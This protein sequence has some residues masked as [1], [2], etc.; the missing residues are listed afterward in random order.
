M[1]VELSARGNSDLGK[2]LRCLLI[3]AVGSVA[4]VGQSHAQQVP[5]SVP[6]L[7]RVTAYGFR[8]S[9]LPM[10]PPM[11]SLNTGPLASMN[12]NSI[13]FFLDGV[14]QAGDFGYDTERPDPSDPSPGTAINP[15][16]DTQCG[17][18]D[19]KAPPAIQNNPVNVVDGYK[20]ASAV[21]FQSVSNPDLR[22]ER[23]KNP[24]WKGIGVLG[25][26]WVTNLDLK[27][28]FSKTG[29]MCYPTPGKPSCNVSSPT[30]LHFYTDQGGVIQMTKSGGNWH[31][32][33]TA[34]MYWVS[35]IDDGTAD[36]GKYL[37]HTRGGSAFGPRMVFRRNGFIDYIDQRDGNRLT[38]TYDTSN[39]LTKVTHTSGRAITLSWT[40]ATPGAVTS[41]QAPNGGVYRFGYYTAG[42]AYASNVEAPILRTV[43]YPDGKGNLEYI[44]ETGTSNSTGTPRP[45]TNVH[46]ML[47]IK[48]NGVPIST[49]TYKL[50]G[51]N[52][53]AV[54]TTQ[55]ANGANRYVYNY[56]FNGG[57]R[58]VI[59][60]YQK[61]TTYHVEDGQIVETVGA[62]TTNCPSTFKLASYLE[63]GLLEYASDER[64]IV[65][66]YEYDSFGRRTK[67]IEAAG[68]PEQRVTT[69]EYDADPTNVL[70]TELIKSITVSGLRRTTYT[71]TPSASTFPNGNS[72]TA[73]VT[74][75]NL[76]NT[77]VANQDRKTSYSY[78][79]HSNGMIATSTED[80]PL[81]GT[82]DR[83]V[84]SYNPL[85]DLV[86]IQNGLGHKRTFSGHNAF[87][88]PT[89][90]TNENGDIIEYTYDLRGRIVKEAR[91]Y[92]GARTETDYLYDLNGRLDSINK[93][94]GASRIFRYDVVGRLI[95][96][97]EVQPNGKYAFESYDYNAAS[98]IVATYRGEIASI[99]GPVNPMPASIPGED[100]G[101]IIAPGIEVSAVPT[102]ATVSYRSI[103]EYDELGRPLRIRGANGQSIRRTYDESGNLATQT[104]AQNN[105]KTFEYD[106]LDRLITSTDPRGKSTRYTYNAADQVVRVTDP[107]GLVT[108]YSYDGFGALWKLTSPDTGVTN[109]TLDA[110]GRVTK[111]VRA[112]GK[113]VIYTHDSLGRILTAVAGGQT[114]EFAYD[115]CSNGKGRIC[116]ITD[117][118]GELTYTYNP[119]GS[120]LTQGQRIGTS[121]I[122]F[123]Q[124]YAYDNLGRLTGISYPGGVS[125]GYGYSLDSLVAVTANIG[126]VAKNVATGIQHL[127][128]G[129]IAG[130]TY[131]NGITRSHQY[132]QGY[133]IGDQRL[134]SI[135][136]RNG[137]S[138]IQSRTLEY[139]TRDLITQI[140]NGVS[141]SATFYEYDE[142]GRLI[143][144]G[145]AADPTRRYTQ[146]EYDD[147]GNRVTK[148]S[149][150][151]GV[152]VPP[153]PTVIEA[154]SNRI[155]NVKGA[156]FTYDNAGNT[157]TSNSNGGMTL[158]YD[159]FNR[160]GK[161]T[162]EGVST[163]YFVNALGQR[164]RKTQGSAATQWV[165][166]Y[167]LGGQL[168]VD[169]HWGPRTWTHY[170]RLPNGSPI[171]VVRG[172][173]LYMAHTDHLGRPEVL[174]NSAKAVVWRSGGGTF[175]TNVSLDQVG[176]LNLG[177][178]GQYRDT[179]SGLWY[180]N[181]R[182]YDPALGRYVESDPIG[183][184]GGINTYIYSA[185]NPLSF[186]DPSGLEIAYANHEVALGIYHSKLV[187]TPI[188][189]A[190]W[191]N[192]PDFK[193]NID[194]NGR[195][196]ATI[197]GGPDV[198]SDVL[199]GGINRINDVTKP[200]SNIT[201][202][203]LPCIY[204]NE[205]SA[206]EKLMGMVGN[207]NNRTVPYTLI[208]V[209]NWQFNSNSFV[210]GIGMAA[211]FTMP[212]HTGA[213]TPGYG[214][215][216][217]S[218]LF[219]R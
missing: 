63:N 207:Y 36:S 104:D 52:T 198:S 73:S 133:A 166:L 206:I 216:L 26:S 115:V 196:F 160:L 18:V 145:S 162:T 205:N 96:Q 30:T 108:N 144:D 15:Q 113:Q 204:K 47:Q 149:R 31:G 203:T 105:S 110:A 183:L 61:K 100:I 219:D 118:T 37:L 19:N 189:Q 112:N 102:G 8:I 153:I 81:G 182:T 50:A 55:L 40:S 134:T 62:A 72:L 184:A 126:G 32:T 199:S 136:S 89:K 119:Q 21:D 82:G 147:N 64:D 101:A 22:F 77:G 176:G 141:G 24:R 177:F 69:W 10:A 129:A 130:W 70:R 120:R 79:F 2:A 25:Q 33:G 212:A 185:A 175:D 76:T 211:G 93:P 85:G 150:A 14:P 92:N 67:A 17:A 180:N 178:P 148:Y 58:E 173:Q 3:A 213:P 124:A 172:G 209:G 131:G 44:H 200:N 60:P 97:Y 114:Q 201:P 39:R 127:P 161:V 217:P 159:A 167:G 94:Y 215:P 152:M 4:A 66:R 59:N 188:D 210:S 195:H 121:S 7:D 74:S 125:L 151:P 48:V 132:D 186:I 29:V 174:T 51:Q 139:D 106:G 109:Y 163:S 192:H 68:R 27:I 140:E 71:Y 65:T 155:D 202:L 146:Y 193:N 191:A 95:G 11:V 56:D 43:S 179:E 5:D 38:Y 28:A 90:V 181:F 197:G 75:R 165:F 86:S 6:T 98:D 135:Y 171:G 54:A 91:F 13:S 214:N 168:D 88:Q 34:S 107:R 128:W 138:F 1:G 103:V 170:L 16:P 9:R 83:K 123:D 41:I 156:P 218:Y 142:L 158:E 111:M 137:S 154:A 53:S 208:P 20:H 42:T 49:Y 35:V 169:Y 23:Y 116:R 80:G 194:S 143:K 187:I 87:G 99:P 78:T 57:S 157:L 117:R 190:Y 45:Y 122:N 164:N 46:R 84:M 12:P